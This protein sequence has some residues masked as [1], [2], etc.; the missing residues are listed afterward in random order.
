MLDYFYA[1]FQEFP[2]QV[3]DTETGKEVDCYDLATVSIVARIE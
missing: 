1:C 3:E 2:V